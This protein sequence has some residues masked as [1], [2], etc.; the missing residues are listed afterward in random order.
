MRLTELDAC[1]CAKVDFSTGNFSEQNEID[2]AQGVMFDCPLCQSHSVLVWFKNPLNAACVP[3]DM[4]PRPGRWTATGTGLS[5]LTL[6]PSI[7]LDTESA[8]KHNSC[9]WHGW[10]KNG[11]AA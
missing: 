8:R 1:F 2:G 5:D 9:L 7:N 10:V 6:N 4:F 11:D 3:D